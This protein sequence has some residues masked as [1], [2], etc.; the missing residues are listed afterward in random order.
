MQ[1]LQLVTRQ[2]SRVSF[3]TGCQS[4]ATGWGVRESVWG[5][6]S[7][8]AVVLPQQTANS[9]TRVGGWCHHWPTGRTPVGRNKHHWI[10]QPLGW[11]NCHKEVALWAR[12]DLLIGNVFKSYRSTYQNVCEPARPGWRHQ[13]WL[14]SCICKIAPGMNSLGCL[15]ARLFNWDQDTKHRCWVRKMRC[16]ECEIFQRVGQ[17]NPA[18]ARIPAKQEKDKDLAAVYI[19]CL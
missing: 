2:S 15:Y 19:H 6:V 1:N 13:S 17:E 14:P 3:A 4:R 5:T 9:T 7:G 12:A 11:W 18:G 8:L 10:K 16:P